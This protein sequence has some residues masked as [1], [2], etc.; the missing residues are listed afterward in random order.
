MERVLLLFEQGRYKEAKEQLS[1]ILSR[2]PN[3][4]SA[5]HILAEI[6]LALDKPK[7]ANQI[8]DRAIAMEPYNDI[9]FGTKARIAIDVEKY[10]DA[11][12]LLQEAIRLNPVVSSYFSMLA[13]ITLSRKQY[14]KAE[15]LANKALSLDPSDLLALNTKSSAQLKLKRH[16]DA[17]N[18]IKGALH[19]DPENSGTHTT[20][21]W[22]KLETGKH[23]E[24]LEHFKEALRHNPNNGYAQAGMREALQAKYIVY[25]YFLKFQFWL[26]NM[27]AKYQWGFIIGFYLLT[28]SLDTIASN[29]P[30]LAPFLTPLVILL[31]LLA[32]STWIIEPITTILFSFNKYAKFLLDARQKKTVLFTGIALVTSILGFLAFFITNYYPYL[33]LAGIALILIIPYRF[34]YLKATYNWIMPAIA[35]FMTLVGLL[36]VYIAFKTGAMFNLLTTVFLISFFAMQWIV[37]AISIKRDNI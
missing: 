2:D 34:I 15:E 26:G 17:E 4:P 19:E 23:L 16:E 10:D 25:R 28:R 22:N 29:V 27:G 8:I 24:A 32:L 9:H 11:E 1:N 30:F 13:S 31:A 21:G 14:Q 12:K 37:N 6:E 3:N 7:E 5:L 18:T 20:Y 36:S 33:T 35:I